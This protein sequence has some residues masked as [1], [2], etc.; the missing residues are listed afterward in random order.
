MSSFGVLDVGFVQKELSDVLDEIVADQIATTEQV[1]APEP[2]KKSR[3]NRDN[4]G[5]QQT[6]PATAPQAEKA[7]SLF[8]RG[9]LS[10]F[11]G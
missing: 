5:R 4:R 8:A 7:D 3:K 10:V 9:V 1:D 2:R 11:G 6:K